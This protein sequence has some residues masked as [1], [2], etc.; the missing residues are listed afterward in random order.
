MAGW[1]E[2]V[3]IMASSGSGCGDSLAVVVAVVG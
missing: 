3:V 2:I 1:Y